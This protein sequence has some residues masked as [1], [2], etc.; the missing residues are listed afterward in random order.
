MQI[1]HIIYNP[2][3][4]AVRLSDGKRSAGWTKVLQLT[5]LHEHYVD[6]EYQASA[7]HIGECFTVLENAG[8]LR[9]C[10]AKTYAA[11]ETLQKSFVNIMGRIAGELTPKE[12]HEQRVPYFP[13]LSTSPLSDRLFLWSVRLERN[14]K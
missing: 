11:S 1:F 2:R 4:E 13:A 14:E 5:G 7:E 10:L 9:S 6:A 8:F 12:L 3:F